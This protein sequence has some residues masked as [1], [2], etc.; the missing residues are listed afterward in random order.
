MFQGWLSTTDGAVA[1]HHCSYAAVAAVVLGL[2]LGFELN[3]CSIDHLSTEESHNVVKLTEQRY[4]HGNVDFGA[5]PEMGSWVEEAQK[6][7]TTYSVIVVAS[8]QHVSNLFR[9]KDRVNA[10]SQGVVSVQFVSPHPRA[11][12]TEYDGAPFS[13]RHAEGVDVRVT[14]V[15]ATDL[16]EAKGYIDDKQV[17]R[18][19]HYHICLSARSAQNK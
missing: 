15:H 12:K 14:I 5:G 16:V 10:F 7:T 8:D 9:D 4:L 13:A 11:V 6:P 18:R 19:R 3:T 1:M 17:I 2:L